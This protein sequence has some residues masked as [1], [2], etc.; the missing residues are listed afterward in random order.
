[1]WVVLP[2]VGLG[3]DE[4]AVGRARRSHGGSLT[5][6]AHERPRRQQ[7]VPRRIAAL[8]C[9]AAVQNDRA[10]PSHCRRNRGSGVTG[11]RGGA[12]VTGKRASRQREHRSRHRDLE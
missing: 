4:V 8:P 11:E 5:G 1:M 7:P 6:Q 10:F 9:S 3:K 12:V 2:L